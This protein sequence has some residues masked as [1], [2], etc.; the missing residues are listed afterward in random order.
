[1]VDDAFGGQSTCG[2]ACGCNSSKRA[3]DGK[4]G[5]AE[6]CGAH[7]LSLSREQFGASS[8]A[9]CGK[10]GKHLSGTSCRPPL[11][12][13]FASGSPAQSPFL[14]YTCTLSSIGLPLDF[15]FSVVAW[16]MNC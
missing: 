12:S 3:G 14:K 16:V 2:D 11:P 7:Y 13:Y 5:G 1:M 4:L 6:S 8:M 10:R 9:M 15:R